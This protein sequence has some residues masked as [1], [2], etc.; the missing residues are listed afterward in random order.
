MPKRMSNFG[1]SNAGNPTA[2]FVLS[3]KCLCLLQFTLSMPKRMSNFGTSNA[4]NPTAFFVLSIEILLGYIC[5][6]KN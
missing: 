6:V 3:I 5:K 2:F 1:T 4:G